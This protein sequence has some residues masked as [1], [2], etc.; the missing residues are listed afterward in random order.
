MGW[1]R[2]SFPLTH[3]AAPSKFRNAFLDSGLKLWY[4]ATTMT[5]LEKLAAY[6]QDLPADQLERLELALDDLLRNLASDDDFTPAEL[7]EIDRRLA[8]DH[9][10]ADQA[11]VE[12]LLG[13]RLP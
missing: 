12:A 13:R 7:A 2:L 10:D 6:A 8:E 3:F 9:E 11:R 4:P 1:A 5:M